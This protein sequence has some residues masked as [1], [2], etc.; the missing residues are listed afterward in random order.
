MVSIGTR[1][2]ETST[3]PA[4][5]CVAAATDAVHPASLANLDL[6]MAGC[7]TAEQVLGLF[8]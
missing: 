8:R 2:V 6:T 7:L 4:S 3:A 5:D 1:N